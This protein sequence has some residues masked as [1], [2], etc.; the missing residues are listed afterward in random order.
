MPMNLT[1]DYLDAGRRFKSAKMAEDKIA[2]IEEIMSMR[3]ALAPIEAGVQLAHLPGHK[4]E[5][6]KA[7]EG[8]AT[9]PQDDTPAG[10]DRAPFM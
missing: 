8:S 3:S 1:P 7:P 10:L 5:K 2:A 9:G 4:F 6:R